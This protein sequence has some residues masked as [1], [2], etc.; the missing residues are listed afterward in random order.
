MNY[1]AIQCGINLLGDGGNVSADEA[2]SILRNSIQLFSVKGNTIGFLS[3]FK[4]AN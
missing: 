3:F 4:I 2:R 1:T